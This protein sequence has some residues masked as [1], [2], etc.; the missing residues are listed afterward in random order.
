MSTGRVTRV[1]ARKQTISHVLRVLSDVVDMVDDDDP[2]V[3]AL[4]DTVCHRI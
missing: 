4:D 1:A 3:K 2:L